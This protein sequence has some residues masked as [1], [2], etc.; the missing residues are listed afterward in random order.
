MLRTCV[1]RK[2]KTTHIYAAALGLPVELPSTGK[3]LIKCHQRLPLLLLS[4]LR[5]VAFR[6]S[7][8]QVP[9]VGQEIWA[10]NNR[11]IVTFF[12]N[13]CLLKKSA[14]LKRN[15][16]ASQKDTL[17]FVPCYVRRLSFLCSQNWSE[18]YPAIC[19]MISHSF[20]R[21]ENSPGSPI[22]H[23]R[24]IGIS[25]QYVVNLEQWKKHHCEWS[26]GLE[27]HLSQAPFIYSIRLRFLYV[28]YANKFWVNSCI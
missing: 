20:A 5:N 13:F 23:Y 22:Y 21:P 8:V 1:W 16:K 14:G 2:A 27:D 6:Q 4:E 9:L 19:S 18:G 24:Y 28:V 7:E 25:V 17:C 26:G 11:R 12:T 3:Q 15:E 10:Q